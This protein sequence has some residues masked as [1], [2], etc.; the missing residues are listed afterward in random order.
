MMK[1]RQYTAGFRHSLIM[2]AAATILLLGNSV[3]PHA[4]PV[5]EVAVTF[6]DLPGL[7]YGADAS[8][9]RLTG[10]NERLL[11]SIMRNNVPAIGFVNAGKLHRAGEL[12]QRTGL[13]QLWLDA[14]LELG[15]HTYSHISID[16]NS[17]EKYEEDLING[18]PVLKALLEKKGMKLTY[19]RH[20]QLRT[21]PTDE[22]KRGLAE[23]L[24][25][26]GYTVAPVTIDNNAYLFAQV[27]GAAKARGDKAAM[28]RIADEYVLY[29]DGIFD[30]FE[31][32]SKETFGYEVKQT[33][34]L[35]ATDLNAEHF[36]DL[37]AMMRKRGYRFVSIG[38]ALKDAAYRL[39]E[40]QTMKG[41]S[42]IHRWR[43]AKGLPLIMEPGEPK[44]ISDLLKAR[45]E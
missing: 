43:L 24:A 3:W 8:L 30:F 21:G 31:K 22:Y 42:W 17:L 1:K 2:F 25:G 29:M 10:L 5:R 36:D 41:L 34:L 45:G 40:A 32:L 14:G 11:A 19:F 23:F 26:R 9:A 38:D 44:F 28:K 12:K 18:E 33:L 16:Q 20:P 6:D 37:A 4:K 13:L 15:N 35:H 27:Y 7:I 39:P